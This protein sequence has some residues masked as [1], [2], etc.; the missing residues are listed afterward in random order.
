MTSAPAR[1]TGAAAALDPAAHRAVLAVMCL[2]LMLVTASMSALNLALPDI[3]LDLSASFTSLT[4]IVDAYTVA[5]AGLVLPLGALGDRVGRRSVL[6]AGSAVFGGA[7]FT[8]SAASTATALILCRVVMGL[9]A[10]MIMPGTLSTITAVFPAERRAK[11]VALWSGCAAAGS[12]LGMLVSG[13]L[14][15]WF[16][17]RSIFITGGLVASVTALAVALRAPESK[18]TRPGRFDTAEA[19]CTALAPGALVYALIAG[20]DQGW[21]TPQV[22]AALAVAVAAAG[23]YVVIGLRTE[24]PL[25]DPRLFRV[26]EFSTGSVALTVRTRYRHQRQPRGQPVHWRSSG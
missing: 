10:A 9:G 4:W 26:P 6:L 24:N 22:I 14:L 20:N 16:S 23:A 1:P 3:G 19:V 18:G 8:A 2:A 5:L 11:A 13:A 21:R 17:W 7:A 12:I 15:E 25:L